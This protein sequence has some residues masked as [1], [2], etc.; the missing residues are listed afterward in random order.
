[1][2]ERLYYHDPYLTSFS[3]QI[4]EAAEDGRRVYLDRS[5]F[6]PSSGGQPNDTGTLNGIAVLDVVDEDDRVAHIL[7][8]PLASTAVEGV[9]NWKRR[10]DHMQQHTGQHLLSAV[11]EELYS[12][13]TISFHLGQDA[14][15]IDV[16]V[17]QLTVDQI[18]GAERR[19]NE[20][21]MENRAVAV[22]FEDAATVQGLRKPSERGGT[23]RVVSIDG[24]D[25][26]AC[27]GTHVTSTAGIGPISIRK[28]DKI[29][30]SVRIEFLCGYRALRRVR[31]DFEKLSE[32]ARVLSAPL[33]EVPELVTALN[34][35]VQD[36]EKARKK[37]AIEL[38]SFQGKQL[39][40]GTA[41]NDAGLRVVKQ[42]QAS[43]AIDDE[44]RALAQSFT[45]GEKAVLLAVFEQPPSLMLA[46]SKDSGVNAGD[47]LKKAL[48]AVGGRG[49]GNP[50]I[51]QGSV[52]NAEALQSLLGVLPW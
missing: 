12:I 13:P 51:A 49:G 29:R 11:L 18:A 2:T 40:A 34:A 41:P 22:T 28:L 27:G 7:R 3:A 32:T 26:S 44:L 36:V 24:I 43:G 45:G 17:P 31:M 15:T 8:A 39:Y 6:Y 4:L 37:L 16:G 30:G 5:A 19:A 38:A 47:V 48:A 46:V 35:R 52:P 14:S 1:M 21:V 9:V 20:I 25:R 10:H 50:Q 23:L 33:D 42:R